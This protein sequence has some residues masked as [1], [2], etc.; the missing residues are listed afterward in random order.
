VKVGV[1][2]PSG[3]LIG[4]SLEKLPRKCSSPYFFTELKSSG[5]FHVTLL[6][7]NFE[8]E[9]LKLVDPVVL[10]GRFLSLVQISLSQFSIRG[11]VFDDVIGGNQDFV[12]NRNLGPLLPSSC[13]NPIVF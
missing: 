6:H 2:F 8:S 3:R 4:G 1:S 10:E 7:I 13:R 11:F 9:F 5:F 12:G